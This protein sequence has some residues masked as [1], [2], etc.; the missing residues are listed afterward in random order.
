LADCSPARPPGPPTTLP[1]MTDAAAVVI[2]DLGGGVNGEADGDAGS[3]TKRVA[4][5]AVDEIVASGGRAVANYDSVEDGEAIVAT[6]IEAFGR[7]D[8]VVNNAGILRDSSFKRMQDSDWEMI[9]RVHLNG[10]YSVTKAAWPYM[11]EQKFGRVITVSSPAGLYGNV[12]QANY[13]MAKSGL[14]GFMQTL[15][16]EGARNGAHIYS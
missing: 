16:K 2:N 11:A 15:A 13:A 8:I 7:V 4:D 6:A 9:I 3:D 12:G 14:N 1:A 10:A 5:L